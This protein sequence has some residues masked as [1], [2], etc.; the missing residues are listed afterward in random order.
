MVENSIL[1]GVQNPRKLCALL[2]KGLGLK[3]AAKELGLKYFTARRIALK[4]ERAGIIE[5][6]STRPGIYRWK[7]ENLHQ[8]RGVTQ[9]AHSRETTKPDT[10]PAE[11]PIMLPAK[12]G[13]TFHLSARPA[14]RFNAQGNFWD[15]QPSRSVRLGR[16]KMQVWL[17]SFRGQTVE[18]II[19]L[20]KADVLEIGQ[21]Q[22]KK[23]GVVAVLD[24]FFYDWEWVD[25]S[26]ERS[27]GV[28][29][30]AGIAQGG[31]RVVAGAIHK[32]ADDSHPENLQFDP[33]PGGDVQ[34][35]TDHAKVHEFIYSHGLA[36]TLYAMGEAIKRLDAKVKEL[37]GK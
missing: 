32:F 30:G 4:Y 22:A 26:R 20:G 6:T 1:R 27:E 5:R 14:V 36:D 34:R 3:E 37:G 21:A 31:R 28:A 24:D 29:N 17:H 16:H 7:R 19:N 13:A 18:E 15:K 12:F 10:S 33:L 9:F 25:T 11:L 23:Y 8:S 35:P 2:C